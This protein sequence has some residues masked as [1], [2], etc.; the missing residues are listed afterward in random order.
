MILPIRIL[1]AASAETWKRKIVSRAAKIL[2][3]EHPYQL[4]VALSLKQ[5]TSGQT[6]SGRLSG[7]RDWWNRWSRPR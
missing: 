6:E 1:S 3:I 5:K 4:Y 7:I 2:F